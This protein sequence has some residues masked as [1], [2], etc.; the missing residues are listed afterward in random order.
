MKIATFGS[1]I[2]KDDRAWKTFGEREQFEVACREIGERIAELGHAIIVGSEN[3]NTADRHI[4]DS[5]L[6]TCVTRKLVGSIIVLR[7]FRECRNYAE[8]S[9]SHPG[10][11]Q[12]VD[13]SNLRSEG[14]KALAVKEADVV[15]TIGGADGTYMAGLGAALGKKPLIPVGSFGGASNDLISALREL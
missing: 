14:M 2:G 10:Y 8:R 3:N 7:P 1:W 15:L 13:R 11:F 5:Y 12:F 6:E 4:A 9:R